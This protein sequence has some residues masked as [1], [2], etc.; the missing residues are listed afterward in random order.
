MAEVVDVT[1]GDTGYRFAV[2]GTGRLRQLG[3]GPGVAATTSAPSVPLELYPLAHPAFDEEPRREPAL[4]VTNASGVTTTR[5]V[6][7][8]VERTTHGTGRAEHAVHLVD[9]AEPLAVTLRFRTWDDE[10]VIEQWVEITNRQAGPVTLQEVAAAAPAFLAGDSWL[11]HF[12]GDWAAEWTTT[13]ELLTL[14]TKVLESRGGIRPHL[15]R[16][17]YFLLSP[18]GPSTEDAGLVVAGALAWGGDLRFAFERAA[19]HQLRALCGHNHAAGG[20]V[21]APGGTFSSPAMTWLWSTS[22][23]GE[24]SRRLHRWIRGHVVRDGHRRRATVLNN[25]EATGFAFDEHRLVGLMDAGAAV[26]AELFLLDDGWFGVEHPRDDDTAG[27]GDWTADDRK[28]PGGLDALTAAASERGLRFGLWVE[29]EMV[30]PRSS[31]YEQHPDWVVAQPGRRRRE[32]RHQLVL[33]ILRPEVRQHV[34]GTIDGLLSDHPGISYLKWDANRMITEPGSTTLPA[35]RQANLW[36]DGPRA[37]RDVMQEVARRHP[38]V[39]LMLCAS[40][41]GRIDLDTLRSFHELW[42]SDNTDP[43]TRVR[44]QYAASHFLPATA[45]AAHVT[46]WGDRPLPFTCAVAL[47]G[48]FGFDL[49]LTALDPGELDVCRRAVELHRDVRDLV[50]QGDQWRL[51]SP[52][53]GDAAAVGFVDPT[54]GRAAVFCYQLGDGLPAELPLPLLDPGIAYEIRS[55]DLTAD[56]PD[57]WRDAAPAHRGAGA[58]WPLREALT[59]WIAVFTPSGAVGQTLR[60]PSE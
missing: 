49:D 36:V 8:D 30:N 1:A 12:G 38:D 13:D 54:T 41:G 32:E 21:L 46:R 56:L 50:Q 40:G 33:D 52:A 45:V 48:R 27:L 7:V 60:R 23:R 6:V 51:L 58:A 3:F 17:P 55:T 39:E 9:E 28:L 5:L 25:W 18:A 10:G 35:D 11:T 31:L 4:R 57:P 20:Y 2:D 19:N 34:V 24:L 37:L 15:Q 26:G 42:L 16:C 59:A 29:P 47:S 22:G 44:M 14:G 53:D 43:V